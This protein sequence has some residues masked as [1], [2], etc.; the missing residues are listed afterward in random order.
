MHRS[1]LCAL[2]LAAVTLLTGCSTAPRTS[3]QEASSTETRA[4]LEEEARFQCL[5]QAMRGVAREL[6]LKLPIACDPAVEA[7]QDVDVKSDLL[8]LAAGGGIYAI[9]RCASPDPRIGLADVT[10]TFATLLGLFEMHQRTPGCEGLSIMVESL[11]PSVD[12]WM[13]LAEEWL[14]PETMACVRQDIADAVRAEQ[15]RVRT[16]TITTAALAAI[17]AVPGEL[18]VNSSFLSFNDNGLLE[19]GIG[20]AHY[21]RLSIQELTDCIALLPL[22]MEYHARRAMLWGAQQPE[23]AALQAQAERAGRSLEALRWLKTLPAAFVA[24]L[25]VQ[26]VLLGVMLR[27]RA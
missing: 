27:R 22:S 5:R 14:P 25:A 1:P 2:T 12:A 13:A 17:V 7:V 19:Y 24:G 26:G 18:Q 6:A 9:V 4:H 10:V 3:L 8:A 23:V 16:S 15:A 11:R 20:E 21:M